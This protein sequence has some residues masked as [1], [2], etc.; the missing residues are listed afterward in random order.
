MNEQKLALVTGASS[1]LGRELVPRL[2]QNGTT[3]IAHY[4]T[5]FPSSIFE[6]LS[7]ESRNK[8]TPLRADFSS[9]DDV[10]QMIETI[11]GQ[12]GTPQQIVHFPALNLRYARLS[13]FD[14]ESFEVDTH[15]QLRSL[16]T[17]LK[18]FLPKTGKSSAVE[19]ARMKIVL[20]LSSV[21]LG[22][23]PK[24][25]AA[26]TMVKYAQLGLL[27]A[28]TAE[29]AEENVRIYGVSPSMIETRFVDGIPT[30]ARE[31]SALQNPMRRNATPKDV[32]PLIEFLLSSNANYINGCNIPITGGSI[33]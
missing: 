13:E 2:V 23:P 8:V 11:R 3:V 4:H 20:I 10:I 14:W 22:M 30:K 6:S 5:D 27:R 32:I 1:E 25:L 24:Y 16:L 18:A 7:A 9:Q 28:V 12:F 33:F 29:Y 21:I 17:L 31:L 19:T 15:I 26:Y